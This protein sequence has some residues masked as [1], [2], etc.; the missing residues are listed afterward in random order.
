MLGSLLL[1]LP[2]VGAA[3]I[4]PRANSQSCPGYKASNV[5]KQARSL[6]AD[7]TLAG[8]PCN[9]YGKDLE[10]LKLLVEYQTDERLHVMIYDAD[11]EV[12]QVPESVLPRV[13]SD[14]DSEDSVLE[15]DYVEEPFSF[16]ISKGDEV[17]FD[18]SASPLVFQSQYVNLRTWLP[19][20]PYVYGLGEHSDPM[21]LPTYNYTRTLWNR[22]AYGTP[23][24][25]NLYGSHPV[26]YDHRGKS[27]TYGVFLLNSNGMDIKINQTTDGKQYLEYNLLGGVLDFYFFY[28]EDPKQ[29][30]MEYSKIVGLPAMQSYWTFGFHQCRYGYRDVYELAEVVYNY[31]Q[32]KIPLETMWTDIDYMDK[33]RVFT[34]D[35]QRFPLEKMRELVTYLHNHDQHYIVMV[36]PA[37]SV[38]NNTAYITGVRDDVFLH[39]QNGSLYEGAVWPGVTVFP[40]WFNEGTQ[41][42]W[43]AQ[44]QQFFDPKSGVDIDALWIDMNEASNFCPYPCLD[45]AA[46][47]ISADLPPAAPPVR[48]SSPIPLPGFPADF[49]PSSKRSVK[50]AQ[51]DKGKKVGLPNRNLTDPPYTI[52]NAA[53][54]LSMS[55]IETDLIHAGEGYAEY[56]TH[57]LYGT[58][59]S[60][61]SRTAMQAR[62]PDVRPLVITRS[63][64]AGAGAH[65]GHWLGDNFSDWVHYRISIAQI[66]SFASMFQ[67]PMVGADVCGFG[68]NTTEELCARWASLGAFYTFYRNHN[69]LGDISQ[70]FYRWPTV[71]ESAR[72]AIDIRY[73]LLDYIYT[74]LHRQ[75]QTGEPFLQ[76]QFYLYPEDSNTFANDRQ[77]FYGDA[78]LVSPVLNE[79]STSVDA[80]FPDDIFYDWYTGAVVRGHGENITL[81]NINITHIPLHIR[82]GNIIP[83]RTSSGMTTTEVRKQGFELI[84]APDLDDTASG[85]LYL[86]DGDSLNPSSVTELEFTYSKGELHVKGTFGQKAVP[87]VEKCTL[88]GKSARTFKGF[89]LDA[90]VNFKLK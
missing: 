74:A 53:G 54:V 18:S 3:V 16:T 61:A 48:P 19:D 77:F 33:R 59:M 51:G 15:F 88:L 80:Y 38:S 17:L 43:T 65:V 50:R 87:K 63:T 64:F 71:A 73:K 10:D 90:P 12:Y 4:G 75:S 89:A 36:D 24:N 49:Q 11:E 67:I 76:P 44:F 27:G 32:A 81:S 52:R 66:L 35:P 37:V 56:D 7:L 68:S 85:S 57:N 40:D 5:Q 9:S 2:L 1:L 42:Y 26:Y 29:A 82:G 55:T 39:N 34:L 58:M 30:S 22:D 13:G 23:N 21:R 72:K 83:V 79:G 84:I 47:A 69:E 78:L 86:D 25:T 62:R 20:D 14:E 31:S 45:P 46:Y 28:G 70:E 6:T 60:S 41:D 8:T